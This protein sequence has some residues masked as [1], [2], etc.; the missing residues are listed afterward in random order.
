MRWLALLVLTESRHTAR[1]VGDSIVL[2]RDQDRRLWDHDMIEEGQTIVRA[3][4]RRDRPGPYQLQAAV[5]A[6]H[7]DA[8]TFAETDWAQILSLYDALSATLARSV[9]TG[10]RRAAVLLDNCDAARVEG[11]LLVDSL[12]GIGWQN[13][14]VISEAGNAVFDNT[15]D[16]LSDLGLEVPPPPELL[17]D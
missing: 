2:L 1:T 12:Y 6:V 15:F 13:G 9:I 3:C 16:R 7:C 5:N 8:A 4:V 14:S 17:E 11:S 10:M